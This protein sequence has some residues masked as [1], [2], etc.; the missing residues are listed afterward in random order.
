MR[1]LAVT[2]CPTG[3]AH[4]YMAAEALKVAAEELGHEIKVE[5]QGAVGIENEITQEDL[6]KASAVIVAADKNIDKSRFKNLT[7]IEVSTQE[8]IRNGKK[9][10]ERAVETDKK[11]K[12]IVNNLAEERIRSS[13]ELLI[14]YK[15]LMTGLSYMVPFMVAGAVLYSLAMKLGI[16]YLGESGKIAS[17]LKFTGEIAFQLSYIAF[18]AY[19]AYSIASTPALLPGMA[20]GFIISYYDGGFIGTMIIGFL[21]GY[22]VLGL[23]KLIR[24]PKPAAGLSPVFIYPVISVLIIG[25]LSTLLLAEPFKIMNINVLSALSGL[26]TI[27]RIVM[28]ALLGAMMAY[29]IGGPVNKAAYTLGVATVGLAQP[30]VIMASVMAAGMVPPLGLALAAILCKEK[31]SKEEK[32]AIKPAI[33]KGFCFITEGVA[34]YLERDSH[35][36][37]LAIITG[38]AIA[39]S[40]TMLLN[41][42]IAVPQGGIFTLFIPGLVQG[43]LLYTLAIVTG[44]IFTAL[45]VILIKDSKNSR[46]VK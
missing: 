9:L 6:E 20:G 4:T 34:P 22:T 45:I 23:K 13:S 5:T 38:S 39:G 7:I 18:S 36:V 15:H 42:S 10:V 40:L 31:F 44:I 17:S 33:I 19:I 30:S 16:S 43:E 35:K 12:V 25:M 37:K 3:I 14:L 1:L 24:L 28:G 27:V 21:A 8:A 46:V 29:D 41:C 26:N 2:A 11:E 32:E